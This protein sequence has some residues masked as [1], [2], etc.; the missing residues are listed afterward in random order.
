MYLYLSWHPTYN[1]ISMPFIFKISDQLTST[2]TLYY[3][4]VPVEFFFYTIANVKS[5]LSP[6]V[7][8]HY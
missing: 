3:F 5:T 8:L 7:Y 1:R 6:D 2:P 4:T